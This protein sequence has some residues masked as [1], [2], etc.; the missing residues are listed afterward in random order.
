[1][2]TDK[3]GNDSVVNRKKAPRIK[4]AVEFDLTLRPYEKYVLD[5]GVE[6][7]AVNTGAEEV[8]MVEWVFNAGNWYEEQ[9]GI[10]AE[11]SAGAATS[12][13]LPPRLPTT[14]IPRAKK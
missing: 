2:R 4:D 3:T 12:A 13:A 9:N 10:A 11:V 14:P 6:V 7:Y 8:M 1:M 5:N